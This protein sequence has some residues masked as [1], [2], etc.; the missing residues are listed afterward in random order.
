M[1][2]ERLFGECS[3]YVIYKALILAYA[4]VYYTATGNTTLTRCIDFN[5]HRLLVLVILL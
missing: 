3:S 1:L 5:I 2:N 4:V